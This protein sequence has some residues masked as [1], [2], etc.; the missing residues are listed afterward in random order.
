[1]KKLVLSLVFVGLG[2]F[3]MAQQTQ[4][5]KFDKVQMQQKHEAK[6][7]NMKQE[8]GLSDAQ[9]AQIKELDT[10]KMEARKAERDQKVA[11]MS[12]KRQQHDSDMKGILTADQYT[13]WE[14]MR[15]E[16]KQE[17]KAQFSERKAHSK[18]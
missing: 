12:A 9:V 15:A 8:L 2:T 1:M 10:K 11:Q 3:A 13:K 17:R 16:K 7:Q 4:A 6:L 5:K 18:K 14:K